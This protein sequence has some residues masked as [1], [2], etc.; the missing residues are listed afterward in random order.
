MSC[1]FHLFAKTRAMFAAFPSLNAS[2][3]TRVLITGFAGVNALL[4]LKIPVTVKE[5]SSSGRNTSSCAGYSP[6]GTIRS[7]PSSAEVFPEAPLSLTMRFPAVIVNVSP[8]AMP[9]LSLNSVEIIS[10]VLFCGKLP[11]IRTSRVS[12]LPSASSSVHKMPLY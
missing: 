7:L 5:R 10:S 3:K 4:V 11:S 6:A 9:N 8:V 12:I 1:P 2:P